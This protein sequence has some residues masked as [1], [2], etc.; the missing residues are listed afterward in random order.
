MRRSSPPSTRLRRLDP[1]KLRP[2]DIVLTSD[3][4]RVSLAIQTFTRSDISHAMIYV[5]SHSIIDANSEGVHARNTQRL[6]FPVDCALYVLT[7]KVPLTP[8]EVEAICTFARSTVGSQYA[9]LEAIQAVSPIRARA[10]RRQFCSRLVAQAYAFAGRPLASRPDFVSPGDLLRSRALRR[11]A[12]ATI[13]LSS[14]EAEAWAEHPDLTQLMRNTTNTV[15]GGARRLEPRI[16]TFDDLD[17]FLVGHPERDVDVL[18]LYE[19]SGYLD[20]WKADLA[21]NGWR[22]DLE[23][24]ADAAARRPVEIE[25]YCRDTV[26]NQAGTCDRYARNLMGYETYLARHGLKTFARLRD[27]YATLAGLDSL[28]TSVARAWLARC[29]GEGAG[30][31]GKAP[32]HSEAW[33]QALEHRNPRQASLAREVVRRAGRPDVCTICGDDSAA[34]LRLVEQGVPE[35]ERLTLKLCNDC[36]TIRTAAGETFERSGTS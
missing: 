30:Q 22:Y 31:F 15:L 11:V 25:A 36:R 13:E 14:E 33:F 28:R 1:A 8:A 24:M 20:V 10:G 16:Q 26:V 17:A 18:A 35:P 23:L 3:H 4:S 9:T 34:D 32:P 7:P 12:E 29:D 19:A 2:G 27:L 6:H 21:Q 5:E